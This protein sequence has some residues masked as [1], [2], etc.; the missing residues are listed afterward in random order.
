M[1]YSLTTHKIPNFMT[2]F[3]HANC[4]TSL[5][6]YRTPLSHKSQIA[7][8]LIYA[9]W[10]SENSATT[11]HRLKTTDIGQDSPKFF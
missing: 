8:I 3:W 10:P 2:R 4:M 7:I 5:R 1:S 6:G 11:A 9:L